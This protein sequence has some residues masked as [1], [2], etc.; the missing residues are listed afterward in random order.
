M[1]DM[2]GD[3]VLDI[4]VTADK[5]SNAGDTR[6]ALYLLFLESEGTV[7]SHRQI[8][9][10]AGGFTVV[11]VVSVLLLLKLWSLLSVWFRW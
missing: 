1:G 7:L 2:N 6:G 5:S 4:G 3:G 8:S 9:D 11:C 10:I